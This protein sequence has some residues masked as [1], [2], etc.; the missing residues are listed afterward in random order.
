MDRQERAG[1]VGVDRPVPLFG[2]QFFDR[3]P[4]PV[5]AGVGEKDVQPAETGGRLGHRPPHLLGVADV[6]DQRRAAPPARRTSSEALISSA[7]ARIS[8]AVWLMTPTFAPSRANRTAAAL[9]MPDPAPVTIAT[10]SLSH[11]IRSF[12]AL[13]SPPVVERVVPARGGKGHLSPAAAR[14][15]AQ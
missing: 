13:E 12:I 4:H 9:P 1:Q 5:D 14:P 11:I 2:L 10:L 8:S 3:G 7:V 6:G 15:L